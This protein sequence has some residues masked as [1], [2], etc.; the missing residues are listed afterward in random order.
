MTSSSV[1]RDLM[2]PFQRRSFASTLLGQDN[3]CCFPLTFTL[4][5]SFVQNMN[6]SV[7]MTGKSA[8]YQ[9]YDNQRIRIESEYT[10]YGQTFKDM[11]LRFKLGSTSYNYHVKDNTC[12]CYVGE[13]IIDKKCVPNTPIVQKAN[14]L[15]LKAFKIEERKSNGYSM[16]EW[17]VQGDHMSGDECLPFRSYMV[18]N[19]LSIVE[20]EGTNVK[21]SV[22]AN[23]FKVPQ[24]CPT[25]DKCS[26]RN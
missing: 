15:N 24:H 18:A 9:D 17:L 10:A 3:L 8:T 4:E 16:N 1:L 11:A 13:F 26:T 7:F 14:I 6:G 23:V 12:T 2:A 19:N 21:A 25:L 5:S 20:T 22:D